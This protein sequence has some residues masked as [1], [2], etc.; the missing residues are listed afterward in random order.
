WDNWLYNQPILPEHL[1][2][3]IPP[4]D[5]M[6]V[7]G[8]DRVVGTG[9]FKYHS[10]TEDRAVYE[11]NDDWWATDQLGLEIQPRYVVDLRNQSNEVVV[12]QLLRGEIDL[13]NNFIPG[14]QFLEGFGDTITT[15]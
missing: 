4:E 11:R 12:P 2:S 3:D 6:A 5:L 10:H 1:W 14:V 15:F 9:P 13:S 8:D 7:A